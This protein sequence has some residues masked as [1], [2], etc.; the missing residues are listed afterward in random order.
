MLQRNETPREFCEIFR[1]DYGLDQ[2]QAVASERIL[3]SNLL[4]TNKL[5]R[6]NS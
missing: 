6:K 5:P 3:H 1:N 2:A 4:R